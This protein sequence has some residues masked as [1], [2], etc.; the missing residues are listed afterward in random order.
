MTAAD[1]PTA[2]ARLRRTHRY[3]LLALCVMAPIAFLA[4]VVAFPERRWVT[5]AAGAAVGI[6]WAVA[7]RSFVKLRCPN[8]GVRLTSSG[9]SRQGTLDGDECPSCGVAFRQRINQ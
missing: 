2:I 9:R 5:L 8:C 7:E 4:T 1:V 6:I 3:W